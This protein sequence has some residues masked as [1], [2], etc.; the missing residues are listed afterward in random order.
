MAYRVIVEQTA[1]D[2][3][4]EY[5]SFMVREWQASEAVAKWL[6]ELQTVIDSLAEMPRRFKLI[7]E[8]AHF[9]I[10][11]RQI[12]FH[13]HRVVFH[14]NDES[15]TVHVLRIYHGARDELTF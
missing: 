2:D 1:Q 4:A 13:S 3:A 10:E 9:V 8:Q 14:V 11:V 6:E 15:N 5:A 7:D 12:V